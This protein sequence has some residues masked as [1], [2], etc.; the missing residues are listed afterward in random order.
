MRALNAKVSWTIQNLMPPYALD[1]PLW[2]DARAMDSVT[3]DEASGALHENDLKDERLPFNEATIDTSVIAMVQTLMMAGFVLGIVAEAI[4]QCHPDTWRAFQAGTQIRTALKLNQL[5]ARRRSKNQM[6]VCCNNTQRPTVI[7]H[8]GKT[9]GI[10]DQQRSWTQ[11]PA[12]QSY[13]KVGM[14][15]PFDELV[16][17]LIDNHTWY[18]NRQGR[19]GACIVGDPRIALTCCTLGMVF[20]PCQ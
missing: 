7:R 1:I 2:L 14:R 4:H 6:Y 3:G 16:P 12:E 19:A 11:H 5:H 13:E 10:E 17:V 18:E 9:E 20:Y 15:H 8:P